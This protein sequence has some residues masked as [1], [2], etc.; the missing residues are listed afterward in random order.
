[1]IFFD[2][3]IGRNEDMM[4]NLKVSQFENVKT[5]RSLR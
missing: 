1:M 4:K 3:I 2:A 5:L